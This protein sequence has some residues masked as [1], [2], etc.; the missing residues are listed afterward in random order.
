[1][2]DLSTIG[3]LFGYG[4]ETTADTCPTSFTALKGAISLPEFSLE[5]QQI[6]TTPI[7]ETLAH[8]FVPGLANDGGSKS[9]EFNNN[10][11]FQ[12]KWA[13]VLSDYETAKASGKAMWFTFYHPDM[14]KA[15][16]FTGE[17][18]RLGF[19]G[20]SVDSANTVQAHIVPNIIKGW[21]VAVKPA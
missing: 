7:D 17:P 12:T 9:I 6:D 4:V 20:A 13:S 19:G 10:D 16:F 5:P 18:T 11:E 14:E 21:L 2:A 15:F 1:M 8:R 3:M